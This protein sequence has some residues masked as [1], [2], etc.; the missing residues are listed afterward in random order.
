[1]YIMSL[2]TEVSAVHRNITITGNIILFTNTF[3]L[4]GIGTVVILEGLPRLFLM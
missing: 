1:M 2:M 3:E 4:A